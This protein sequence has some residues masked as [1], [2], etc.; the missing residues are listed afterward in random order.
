MQQYHDA[1][2]HVIKCGTKVH[3]RT[4]TDTICVFGYQM[5]FDLSAGFPAITTKRLAWKAVVGELLW[6]LEG[7]MDERRLAELTY[8]QPRQNLI[9]KSTIWTANADTQGVQL[10]YSN[11]PEHKFLGPIYGHQWRNFDGATYNSQPQYSGK[12]QI[13]DILE[14]LQHSKE[15][16]RILLSAWNPNQLHEMA[17][18][19]CHVLAQ[20]RVLD[21]KLSCQL[22]QRSCDLGLGA[23]FNIASYSL[24]THIF[25]R[26]CGLDVG[27][28]VYTVGDMHI[29]ENHIEPLKTQITR[30]AYELPTL[31]IDDSFNLE[32]GLCAGFALGDRDKFELVGYKHHPTIS[33]DM[34]V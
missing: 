25:A 32:A 7:S 27:D 4:G 10:G 19:P 8:G 1:V 18:P 17:L 15:S 24:L 28:F 21:N 23:P 9:D 30:Q 5:R 2:E 14:Q 26:E 22:Y 6:F 33:M 29:Y 16:R 13:R 12:D 3:N 20:F 34:A 31:R 11:C